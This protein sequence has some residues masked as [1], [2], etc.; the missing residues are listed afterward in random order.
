MKPIFIMSSERSGSNLLRKMLGMHS[1][2]A[3]PPPPHMWRHLMKVAANYGPLNDQEQFRKLVEQAIRMTQVPGSHLEWK[4]QFTVQE[5]LDQCHTPNVSGII[6]TLYTLYSQREGAEGWVCKENKLFNHAFQILE[7]VPDAK[8][9]Y[10]CRDGRDV[11]CSI[12]KVA[13]HDQH[14]YFI[15]EEWKQEQQKCL[16]VYQELINKGSVKLV[17]YEDLIENPQSV[18]EEI[19]T[20]VGISFEEAMLYF[21]ES[22]SAVKEA[23][24]SNF[25]ENLS[26]PVMSDNKGKFLKQLSPKETRIFESLTADILSNLGYPI[27]YTSNTFKVGKL[28]Y[29]LYKIYNEIYKKINLRLYYKEEGRKKRAE[30]LSEIHNSHTS[31][32][33]FADTISYKK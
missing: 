32:T 31:E 9:I 22:R 23:E 25:W 33:T 18:L 6:N 21:H 8:F 10:L 19:C 5:V 14:V 24:K 17:R 15:A 13:T 1:I 7:V 30:M 16:Q 11:A 3:A 2:L 28:R 12:K 27:T 4:Y 26:K 29:L 20:F